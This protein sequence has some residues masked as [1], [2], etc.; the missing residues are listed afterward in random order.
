MQMEHRIGPHR[1]VIEDD[2]ALSYSDQAVTAT[3]MQQLLDICASVRDRWNRL[4][5][6]TIMGP[7]F[8]MTPDA[9]KL[10]SEWGRKHE[11]T[12][13][14]VVGASLAMRTLLGLIGRA[15][16]LLGGRPD[17]IKF[18]ATESE[19]RSII[20]KHKAGLAPAG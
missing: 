7:G 4:Y 6:V 5:V 19:A 10:A 8:D 13:N 18:A 9:R 20:A 11:M 15:H 16:R 17:E 1:L 2:V 3:E 14:V 12:L